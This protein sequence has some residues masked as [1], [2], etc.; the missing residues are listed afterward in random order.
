MSKGTKWRLQRIQKL[1]HPTM[2]EPLC[3]QWKLASYEPPRPTRPPTADPT[4]CT[5]TSAAD[6]ADG[7]LGDSGLDSGG[8]G[9]VS[10]GTVMLP[11]NDQQFDDWGGAAQESSDEEWNSP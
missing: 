6:A 2:Q 7:D 9:L 8:I 3:R 1:I 4:D 5:L 11:Y 10:G